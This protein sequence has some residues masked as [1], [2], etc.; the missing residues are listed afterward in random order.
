MNIQAKTNEELTKL[1][2]F[3]RKIFMVQIKLQQD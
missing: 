2:N 1:S 3:K